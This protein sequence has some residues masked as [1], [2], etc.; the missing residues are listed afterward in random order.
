MSSL[1]Y[2]QYNHQSNGDARSLF[3]MN[4]LAVHFLEEQNFDLYGIVL[5]F[6]WVTW[7]CP[8]PSARWHS[9]SNTT[10]KRNDT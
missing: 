8:T 6:R 3:R 9:Q 5:H 7:E 2:D 1:V 4:K 10:Q